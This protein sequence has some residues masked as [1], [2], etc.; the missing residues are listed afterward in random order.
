M[1]YKIVIPARAGSKRFKNKN[2]AQLDSKPLISHTIE[3]ALIFFPKEDIWINTDDNEIIKISKN[4]EV[5]ITKRPMMLG[6]D[7][8]S[9]AEVLKYQCQVFETLKISCDAVILLQVTNPIRPNNLLSKTIHLFEENNRSSLASFT[10]LNKKFGKIENCSFIPQNYIPGQRMQ[11]ITP[12]FFENGLIYIT[13]FQDLINGNI[14]T[15]DVYPYIYNGIESMVDID[16]PEDL[17]FAE[18]IF[19]KINDKI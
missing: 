2:I 4:Y 16:E 11:D 9:T 15:D 17:I 7:T 6:Y 5:N 14:I 10:S 3:Y 1:K 13:K 12:S 18:Y 19:K 8:T